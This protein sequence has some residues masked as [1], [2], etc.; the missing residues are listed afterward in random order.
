MCMILHARHLQPVPSRHS[1]RA[2]SSPLG[3]LL[4]HNR[5]LRSRRRSSRDQPCR[6][7]QTTGFRNLSRLGSRWSMDFKGAPNDGTPIP[8]SFLCYRGFLWEQG[9][10]HRVSRKK[11]HQFGSTIIL[12]NRLPMADAGCQCRLPVAGWQNM[13]IIISL[14]NYY[15]YIIYACVYVYIYI[16]KNSKHMWDLVHENATGHDWTTF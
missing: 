16:F 5:P 13:Y 3:S 9:F 2:S 12:D 15:I 1:R 14:Y 7:K 11:I 10:Q 8:M 4:S 6:H